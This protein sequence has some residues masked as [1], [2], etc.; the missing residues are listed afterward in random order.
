MANITGNLMGHTLRGFEEG[1]KWSWIGSK[2]RESNLD[3]IQIEQEC[4]GIGLY[5]D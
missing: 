4:L 2:L 5:R 3:E 1:T